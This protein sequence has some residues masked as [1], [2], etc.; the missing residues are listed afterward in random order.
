MRILILGALAATLAGCAPSVRETSL[1]GLD[2]ADGE[3]LS[4]LQDSLPQDDRAALG[5][6]ALLHWPKSKFYCG[7]PI[8]GRG[9]LAATIGEAI[10]QTR[11]YEIA[12]ATARAEART[13]AAFSARQQET[14][15]VTRMEQ[16]VFERDLLY[17]RMGPA[18]DGTPR[19]A[20]IKKR[21][22]EMRTELN[23]LRAR[24]FR[25]ATP[26]L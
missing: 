5:T 17:G 1:T 25:S 4:A 10:D 24:P 2:L 6:Y 9:A 13:G 19:G 16:L 20:E 14:E 3:I 12:L 18:A 21:L 26:R 8:G 15:L 11:A 22:G 23:A 7:K